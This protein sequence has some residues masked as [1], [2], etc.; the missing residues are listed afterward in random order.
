MSSPAPRALAIPSRLGDYDVRFEPDLSFIQQLIRLPRRLFVVDATVWEIH[1]PSAL[2][3]I[4]E[5]ETLIL[6]IHEDRKNLDSVRAVYER[7]LAS[8][9]KRNLTLIAIGGG[10]LQDIAGYAASTLY[11][12][13]PWVFVPTTLLAQADSCIGGKTS[14]NYGEYKNLLGTFYPPRAV[15][16]HIEFLKTQLEGDF[17]SGLGEVVKLHLLGAERHGELA[18]QV[19]PALLPPMVQR[20][21][22]AL[23]D[24]VQRSLAIKR[25]FIVDDEFDTGRR[26]L[27]N[28]GHC[29]GHA[30]ESVSQFRIPHGQGVVVG[31]IAANMA[32]RN[33]GWLNAAD[34]KDVRTRLLLPILK[35]KPDRADLE[36][37]PIIEAMKKD[38]KR[39]GEGLPLILYRDGCIFERIGDLT[40]GEV[41]EVLAELR[42]LFRE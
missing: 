20:D 15:H 29:F 21:S 7:L 26:N 42:E 17:F 36:D 9:A 41:A 40:F 24:G 5:A 25:D 19:L 28:Y 13:I 2:G 4:P 27:L 16:I 31:M 10:I 34:E 22:A 35:L 32:A 11:R 1:H 12:G 37:G 6:P 30:L 14:L 38:K 39:T 8:A 18:S 33:R 3:D 23:L